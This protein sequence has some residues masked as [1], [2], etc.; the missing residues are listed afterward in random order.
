MAVNGW[1]PKFMDNFTGWQEL[2]FPW[3]VF[4]HDPDFQP[5][6]APNDG[7][8]LTAVEAFAFAPGAPSNGRYAMDQIVLFKNVA[9]PDA[10]QVAFSSQTYSVSEGQSVT[11]TVALSFAI[12]DTVTVDYATAD[13]TATSSDYTPVSGT[14]TF[15]PGELTQTII[16]DTIDNSDLDDDRTFTVQLADPVNAE[17]GAWDIATVTIEDDEVP[18]HSN[19]K[20][21]IV[22]DFE[23][24]LPAGE[25]ANGL[26]IGFITWGDFWNNTTVEITTTLVAD[27]DPL[28]LPGQSGDNHLLQFD[29]NVT[30]WGGLTHAFENEEVDT[31]VT[32][33]WTSYE[34]I[35]FWLYGQNTG[36]DLLFEIQDNRNPGSTVADTEI[37][38]HAFVDDFSGWQLFM[39]DF[40]DDFIRK[41]IGNGAPNDGFGREEVHG[42]AFGSLSTGGADVTYYLDDVA[43]IVRTTMIDDFENGLPA[44]EDANG[45]GIG[46]ITWGDFWNNT[47]VAI[48]T[49][50]V[51]DSDPLA[52]PG[53][54]GDNHLLQFDAN[55][56]G[57]GGFTHAF[58]NETVDTW[59]TQDWTS[60]EGICFWIYGQN[61]G[62][63][64]L[65]EIQ[66][67]RNP[68][69]IVADTEI[70]SHAFVD[71]F[72]GWR[73]FMLDFDEDFIRKE[74]GN[75]APNDGFGREEVHGWA[76]G[77]LSTGGADVTYYLDD[78]M[79]YGNSGSDQ[80][81]LVAF[82]LGQVSVDE[83]ETAVLTVALSRAH[84]ETVTVE[85]ATAESNARPYQY[86]PISGTLTFPAG[87]VEQTISIPTYHDGKHTRDVR[88][89]V[90]LY[91]GW[92]PAWLPA[93]RH[94]HHRRQ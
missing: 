56:T 88:V 11:L 47:T 23:N 80:P 42:W 50:L 79:V 6:G 17:L 1:R 72:S 53:Q 58:E 65:F 8:T 92:R 5:G 39:L 63:D 85:Y 83:G 14:L 54:S 87:T 68:G 84:S 77:S 43:L 34:G 9:G 59:V 78:V 20:T 40:D 67:N 71:D 70:W 33:D 30:G 91:E 73:L 44:G 66:D 19:A 46:F 75:G 25:D 45:L 29:A 4:Y 18:D 76:F 62:N 60:Y 10:L 49:T 89:A 32:Q 74:I 2:R 7:P 57:W 21:E 86:T 31:W 26:G 28:A 36:N 64:L 61:T 94:P 15:D 3:Q 52:L 37:W 51:A 93:P 69:S 81:L 82:D 12:T 48:T 35:S 16:V 38:S 13:G 27:S 55:V 22:D 24:G 41:E 90:N